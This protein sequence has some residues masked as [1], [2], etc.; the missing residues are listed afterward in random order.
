MPNLMP[1]GSHWGG[2]SRLSAK[3]YNTSSSLCEYVVLRDRS[4]DQTTMIVSYRSKANAKCQ[5]R[6]VKWED[7]TP[8][9]PMLPLSISV[10]LRR[11]SSSSFDTMSSESMTQNVWQLCFDFLDLPSLQ[12]CSLVCKE[13]YE[14][15]K[16]PYLWLTAYCRDYRNN[17]RLSRKFMLLSYTNLIKMNMLRN[18]CD[19]KLSTRSRTTVL[20]DQKIHILNNSMLRSFLRGAVDSVRSYKALPVLSSAS[21]LG[22]Q[23]S[24]YEVTQIKGCASVGIASV[25]DKPS[26]NAYGF[27]MDDHVG[28]KGISFGYH[29]HDGTFVAHNGEANY[30][31]VRSSFG[32]GFGKDNESNPDGST[33]GCG[34]NHATRELFFTLNGRM[35]GAPPVLIPMENVRYAAAIALHSFNDSCVLNLGAAAFSFDIEEYCLS[36]AIFVMYAAIVTKEDTNR[37]IKSLSSIVNIPIKQKKQTKSQRRA[38]RAKAEAVPIKVVQWVEECLDDIIWQLIF[39]CLDLPSLLHARLTC[40]LFKL[41]AENPR[42]WSAFYAQQ[43][44]RGNSLS[45]FYNVCTWQQLYTMNRSRHRL[46]VP[47]STR[48]KATECPLT[49]SVEVLNNSMLRSFERGTIDSIRSTAPLP[50]LSCSNAFNITAV[51][52][53]VEVSSHHYVSIGFVSLND[54]RAYGFGSDAHVGWLPFSY[55]YHTQGTGLVYHDGS[56]M[57]EAPGAFTS[58][59]CRN[60]PKTSVYN[61]SDNYDVIGCGYVNDTVFFTLN[62]ILLGHVPCSLPGDM[63]FA[64]AVSIHALDASVVINWG[65]LAFEFDVENYITQWLQL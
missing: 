62:G 45:S 15:A 17:Q 20:P 2:S 24:Y 50:C 34:F 29:S 19:L 43:W 5:Q 65:T 44:L 60:R 11:R 22:I 18:Q 10:P 14:V 37:R 55:G 51:Y 57:V 49:H 3:S 8:A 31:G 46:R 52:F 59:E 1:M 9:T 16:L 58:W 56:S 41:N 36:L 28:W 6:S 33:V 54:P 7:L 47:L 32:P 23:V 27:G 38:A 64:G 12:Q 35:I 40:Q 39:E 21:A 42:L 30:G 26:M 13:M 61:L 53:E 4:I 63:N 25:H 48:A